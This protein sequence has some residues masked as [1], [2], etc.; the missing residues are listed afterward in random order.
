MGGYY[1]GYGSLTSQRFVQRL[2]LGANARKVGVYLWWLGQVQ[3]GGL[4]LVVGA[5]F[6]E[7]GASS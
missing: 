2:F 5:A 3:L 6:A 1:L 7:A 4:T